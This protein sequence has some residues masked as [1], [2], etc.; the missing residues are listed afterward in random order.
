MARLT[1]L[2]ETGRTVSG[3]NTPRRPIT[4]NCV[5]FE[6][7]LNDLIRKAIA[8]NMSPEA[9]DAEIEYRE[10]CEEH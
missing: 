6:R 1:S 2:T 8:A 4:R 5:R 3:K 10:Y 7:M 9:D